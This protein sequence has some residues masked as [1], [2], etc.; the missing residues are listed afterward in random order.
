MF[1]FFPRTPFSAQIYGPEKSLKGG[2]LLSHPETNEALETSSGHVRPWNK[3][4]QHAQNR[5]WILHMTS[6]LVCECGLAA[7][8]CRTFLHPSST[9]F[10]CMPATQY[11][12][13][14]SLK[15]TSHKHQILCALIHTSFG[16]HLRDKLCM[17]SHAKACR[18]IFR[19]TNP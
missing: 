8:H 16:Q 1:C 10:G 17:P 13:S 5:L 11:Y 19:C 7:G 9:F 6:L 3:Q 18:D 12:G 2:L 14:R 4:K 15:D